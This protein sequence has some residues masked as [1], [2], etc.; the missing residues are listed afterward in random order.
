MPK[1]GQNC[2]K[3]AETGRKGKN[4]CQVKKSRTFTLASI[5]SKFPLRSAEA[6][7]PVIPEYF[8]SAFP[9]FLIPVLSHGALM[10]LSLFPQHKKLGSAVPWRL[11]SFH[12]FWYRRTFACAMKTNGEGATEG[13]PVLP[14]RPSFPRFPFFPCGN[15]K[16]L[17]K[18]MTRKKHKKRQICI[19][20]SPLP[21]CAVA[22]FTYV[23]T[24]TWTHM[25]IYVYMYVYVYVYV[26]MHIYIK[27]DI[28]MYKVYV[29]IC[30]EIYVHTYIYTYIYVHTYI[31]TYIRRNTPTHTHI[32]THILGPQGGANRIRLTIHVYTCIHTNINT[33]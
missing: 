18:K 31:H 9:V 6:F 26:R 23:Y 29:C 20:I 13:T 12:L 17:S 11:K 3:F 4:K 7:I 25:H 33:W 10:A 32:Y 8:F 14:R 2:Q 16:I 24:Y 28:H 1:I 30:I 21:S 19:C 22:P 5:S 15:Q 27:Y